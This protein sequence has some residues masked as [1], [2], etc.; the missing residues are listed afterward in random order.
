MTAS[1]Y[2]IVSWPGPVTFADSISGPMPSDTAVLCLAS[3]ALD[4]GSAMAPE[5]E[6]ASPVTSPD[7]VLYRRTTPSGLVSSMSELS[8]STTE[9][10]FETAV[11]ESTV[12]PAA[13]VPDTDQP[14]AVVSR[15]V[16]F[17]LK[18]TVISSSPVAS[19]VKVGACPSVSCCETLP[20]PRALLEPSLIAP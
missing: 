15:T 5:P 3:R 12:R 9:R 16:R 17:S 8:V 14:C 6:F 20:E 7:E 10:P 11:L 4:A 19:A 13:S 1:L 18:V 2:V